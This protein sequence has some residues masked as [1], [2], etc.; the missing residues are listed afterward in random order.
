MNGLGMSTASRKR[1][2]K[3]TLALSIPSMLN[4][5]ISFVLVLIISRYLGVQ[6][7]GQYSL[8][9]AYLGIFA[10]LAVLGLDHLVV[11]EAAKRPED[12]HL[13]F[14]NAGLFGTVSSLV[15]LLA[16][17]LLIAVMGYEKVV[18]Q[19]GFIC[20]LSLV[21]S[22]AIGYM[23]AIFRSVEKAEYV[24]FTYLPEN[25]VRVAVC[26]VLI[27]SGYGITALFTAILGT[28]ILAAVMMFIFYVKVLG[29]PGARLD[30][31]VWRLLAAEAPTFASIAVFS[32]IHLSLDQIM[33]SKLKSVDAVGIYSAADRLLDI[34]RTTP[35]AFAAALLPVLTREFLEG[36]DRLHKL[37]VDSLRYLFIGTIP[38]VVGT[39]LLSDQI[40]TLIYGVKFEASIPVLTL[41]IVSLVPFSMAFVLAQVLIAT[42]N[43]RV[44]LAVNIAAAIINFVLNLMLIPMWG[45]WGAALA[46]LITIVIF[47]QLQYL[48]IRQRLFRIAFA[49]LVPKPL[50]AAGVMACATYVLRDL[51]VFLNIGLSAAVYFA[52]LL[53]VRG[54]SAEDT[55]FLR[56][57]IRDRFPRS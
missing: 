51:N 35:T 26:A 49:G 19:A 22:T 48:F 25:V 39:A 44:D 21:A 12:I 24:T 55:D 53:A 15:S 45:A 6:G 30:G 32:T 42:N 52:V 28:R 29:M 23:E 7:L 17:N 8:V 9:L 10:T 41:H 3:N 50:V 38:V 37:T 54:F 43:Q 57:L 36:V 27:L 13:L 14:F 31:R 46:T 40:I 5:V 16:M 2:F 11:R 4:P 20:S 33:L 1:I 18:V 34:C 47:N 56:R